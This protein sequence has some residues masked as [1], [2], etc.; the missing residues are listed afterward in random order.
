[1]LDSFLL[2]NTFCH[3]TFPGFPF[4]LYITL[5]YST[6]TQKF[7]LDTS[8]LSYTSSYGAAHWSG[9]EIKNGWQFWVNPLYKRAQ[10]SKVASNILF[11]F[12]NHQEAVLFMFLLLLLLSS[13]LQW[14]HRLFLLR[15]CP[16]QLAFSMNDMV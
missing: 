2:F 15:I 11:C 14:H 1:M 7:T 10:M 3:F 4:I 9:A 16:V 12:P 6:Y 13:V 5:Q 8:N